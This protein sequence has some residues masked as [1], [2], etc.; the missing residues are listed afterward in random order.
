V[1]VD[2]FPRYGKGNHL[3]K[4]S[5]SRAYDDWYEQKHWICKNGVCLLVGLTEKKRLFMQSRFPK[6]KPYTINRNVVRRVF[7]KPRNIQT[8]LKKVFVVGVIAFI[9]ESYEDLSLSLF[10]QRKP[11]MSPMLRFRSTGVTRYSRSHLISLN[12]FLDRVCVCVEALRKS[13]AS[14]QAANTFPLSVFEIHTHRI[15]RGPNTM[16]SP[17]VHSAAQRASLSLIISSA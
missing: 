14:P 8:L 12:R 4:A 10:M 15:A 17:C 1:C 3:K 7:K 6:A 11:V 9:P 13:V 5:Q 2:S 16:M